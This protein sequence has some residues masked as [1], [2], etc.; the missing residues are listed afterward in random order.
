L[1]KQEEHLKLDTKNI[2]AIR[3]NRPDAGY[4]R[5]IL[6]TGYTYGNIGNT[7]AI[8]RKARKRRFLN[9][10]EKYYIFL[11]SKQ[12]IRMNEF[13][14]DHNNPIYETVFQQLKRVSPQ[15]AAHHPRP[16]PI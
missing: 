4:C 12:D 7:M 14:I 10:L 1:A 8:I 6:D 2:Q 9:S 5:H 11:A 15:I 3:N 13:R 16:S